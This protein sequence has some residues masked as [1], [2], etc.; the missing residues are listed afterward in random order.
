MNSSVPSARL[1]EAP[2][3]RRWA[4]TAPLAAAVALAVVLPRLIVLYVSVIDWDE[5]FYAL[6]AQQWLAGHVPYE[7]VF[8]HKPIG[9]YAIFA[10]FFLLFGD[11]VI[12]IRLIALVFVAATAVLLGRAAEAQ[13]GRSPWLAAWVAALYGIASLANGGLATNTEI[14]VNF[15]VVLALWL[16]VA[17]DPQS[18]LSVPRCVAIGG[19]LGL[20]FQVNYLAG[21]LAAG[22]AG[23]YLCWIWNSQPLDVLTRRYIRDGNLFR[24]NAAAKLGL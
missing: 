19:S 18:R 21:I 9:L 13:F 6:I 14:L 16:V 7:T 5:S 20:A 17:S 22:A 2:L 24:D 11:S 8:D 12:A 3:K 23:F 4:A 1:S 15:F 10:S